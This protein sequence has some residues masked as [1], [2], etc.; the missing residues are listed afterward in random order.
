MG[1]FNFTFDE[2]ELNDYLIK[3]DPIKLKYDVNKNSRCYDS[4]IRYEQTF[5]PIDY[6]KKDTVSFLEN[7]VL[8]YGGSEDDSNQFLWKYKIV[9]DKLLNRYV[10]IFG[11][12]RLFDER[13]IEFEWDMHSR[14]DFNNHSISYYR[15]HFIHQLRDC[16]MLLRLLENPSIYKQVNAILHNKT[17]SKV[18]RFFN[19]CIEKLS[20]N[21]CDNRKFYS[22]IKGLYREQANQKSFNDYVNIFY[23]KYIIYSSAIISSL[24]HDIGYPIV[25]YFGYQKRLLK[26]AP[27][28]YMLINGDKS[29]N[30]KIAALLSQ[31]LLFQVVGKE[32]ILYNSDGNHGAFS[33]I[34]LLLH[35]YETGLIYSLPLEQ[36]AAVELAALAIYNHTIQYQYIKG[37]KKKDECKYYRAQFNLNPISFLLR[38]CDDAQEWNRTYFEISNTPTLLY[39]RKCQTPLKRIK[40]GEKDS[41]ENYYCECQSNNTCFRLNGTEFNRRVIYNVT[42]SKVLRIY[43][44]ERE[45]LIFDFDYDY[46]KLLRMCSISPTYAKQRTKEL[47]YIKALVTAQNIGYKNGVI[48]NF[49]M[50]N[51]P[52][53]IKSFI[54]HDFKKKIKFN[55]M[56]SGIIPYTTKDYNSFLNAYNAFIQQLSSFTIK[57]IQK[58]KSKNIRNSMLTKKL[59]KHWCEQQLFFYLLIS[60]IGETISL[61]ED[62]KKLKIEDLIVKTESL[63]FMLYKLYLDVGGIQSELI[64]KLLEDTFLQYAKKGDIQKEKYLKSS[65]YKD[66]MVSN[67]SLLFDINCYCNVNNELNKIKKNN[68]F[69]LDY[70]SDLYLFECLNMIINAKY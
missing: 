25:H 2:N 11:L 46:F 33:A 32:D 50:S 13:Y 64:L 37:D 20:F 63:A 60:D 7:T 45:N 19:E 31:S 5:K 48:I 3:F 40:L 57:V 53:L 15:D 17:M 16:F 54:I 38:L 49:F 1:S 6:T 30:E 27:S 56:Y 66:Y 8:V 22:L 42:P 43:D 58:F 10:G 44:N 59:T 65:F 23:S 9:S 34:A 26:F 67:D 55:I 24:F 12:S 36:K 18:S 47:N 41:D 35:F 4:I 61:N 69:S 39:C 62:W 21:I 29:S 70:Y 51:N 28:V 52:I 14:M 68:S